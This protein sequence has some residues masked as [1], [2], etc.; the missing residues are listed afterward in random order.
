[1]PKQ[2]KGAPDRWEASRKRKGDTKYFTPYKL[3]SKEGGPIVL[4]RKKNP[5]SQSKKRE[6]RPPQPPPPRTDETEKNQRYPPKEGSTWKSPQKK[7]ENYCTEGDTQRHIGKRR[8]CFLF[9][10]RDSASK[11]KKKKG[12]RS[13]GGK[14]LTYTACQCKGDKKKEGEKQV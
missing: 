7:R 4:R 3:F 13:K 2:E 12:S 9:E 1:L 5:H 11:K 6:K 8:K 14:R 10:K